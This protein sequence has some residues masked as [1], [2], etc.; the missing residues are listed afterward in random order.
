MTKRHD[1]ILLACLYEGK[2]DAFLGSGLLGP[3]GLLASTDGHLDNHSNEHLYE[4][5]VARAR[6]GPRV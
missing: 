4:D 6:D 3:S 2:A 1:R 5:G